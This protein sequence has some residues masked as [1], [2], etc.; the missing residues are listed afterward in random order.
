MHRIPFVIEHKITSYLDVPT[1]IR[2]QQCS[3]YWHNTKA[4][5]M[6]RSIQT[7]D[8]SRVAKFCPEEIKGDTLYFPEMKTV[9]RVEATLVTGLNNLPNLE[10]LSGIRYSIN[11]KSTKI[12]SFNFKNMTLRQSREQL[13]LLP[14]TVTE[15]I[16]ISPELISAN[17]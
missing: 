17:L 12:R 5:P 9:K 3:K 11:C 14:P 2:L 10:S 8:P 13:S 7:S 16:S 15:F 6:I 4:I 1:F